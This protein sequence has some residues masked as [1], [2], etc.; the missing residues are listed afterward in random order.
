LFA[1]VAIVVA[2]PYFYGW[3]N[4]RSSRP[5]AVKARAKR[6]RR[7]PVAARSWPTV[8]FLG[9]CALLVTIRA[10]DLISERAHIS[11]SES[12]LFGV[13]MSS[14]YPEHA[15]EFVLRE[16]LPGNIFHEYSMGGYVAFRLGPQYPDYIDGRAIPFSD[17]MFEERKMMRQLPDS[18]AWQ[19]EADQ[20]G[21]NTLFFSVA[22]KGGLGSTHVQQFC[23]S[24]AWKPVYLD[25]EG[26]VFVRNR[27]ENAALINRL[28]VDCSK[29]QF[30]PPAALAADT[31]FRGRAEL[32]NFYANAGSILFN[33]GRNP[34]AA[35]ALDRAL[36]M[37][38][39]EPYLHHTRG[40]LYQASRQF[41]EAEREYLVSARL[42]PSEVNWSSLGSLY[43]SQSRYVEAVS[44]VRHAAG[45]SARPS[46]HYLFLEQ[47]YLAM[48][49][50]Q[51]ALAALDAAIEQSDYEPPDVK[52]EIAVQVA[53]GRAQ[54]WAKLGDL[55]R[56][57]GFQQEA[58]SDDPSNPQRWIALADLYAAQGQAELAQYARQRAQALNRPKP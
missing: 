18:A 55:G 19:Q 21:I 47:I 24:Q 39:E 35:Q 54:V 30:V 42:A 58:L 36:Q 57:V 5:A 23:A 11:A 32:F 7:E 56:A 33:L 43:Y 8:A 10:Y 3:F 25:E 17:V 45:F 13:G 2:A 28:Q 16:R 46:V 27:P 53:Q 49:Q 34:E 37:F 31:S 4:G 40:Q 22:R 29:V 26:A 41:Q 15:A 12:T 9:V 44:A 6:E 38:P 1:I 20:W 48:N 14:L 52:K 51:D 50:P